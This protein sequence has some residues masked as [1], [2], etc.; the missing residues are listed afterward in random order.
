MYAATVGQR[1]Q[2]LSHRRRGSSRHIGHH[3]RFHHK[4]APQIAQNL[5]QAVHILG[6]VSQTH[7]AQVLSRYRILATFGKTAHIIQFVAQS[8]LVQRRQISESGEKQFL[9]QLRGLAQLFQNQ[10][11]ANHLAGYARKV[12]LHLRLVG[13]TRLSHRAAQGGRSFVNLTR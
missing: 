13:N 3:Q 10:G 12:R 7:L 8:L 4:T 9:L 1:H 2:H 6:H 11:M 5:P